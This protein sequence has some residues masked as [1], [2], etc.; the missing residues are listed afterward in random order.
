MLLSGL[1]SFGGGA[2]RTWCVAQIAIGS[3]FEAIH[4]APRRVVTIDLVA[5]IRIFVPERR[6]VAY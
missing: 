4:P 5:V 6:L 3:G 1:F 2:T